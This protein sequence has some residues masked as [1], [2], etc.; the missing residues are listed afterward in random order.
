MNISEAVAILKLNKLSFF[1]SWS[2]A[3]AY[4]LYSLGREK[5]LLLNVSTF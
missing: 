2:L 1:I 4:C 5:Y 3:L